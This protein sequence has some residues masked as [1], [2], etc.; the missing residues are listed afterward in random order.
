MTVPLL[1]TDRKLRA[2][3]RT[4]ERQQALR[5]GNTYTNSI[6]QILIESI[7]CLQVHRVLK[8]ICKGDQEYCS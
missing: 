2:S 5:Q 4:D 8:F 3:E 1:A 7:E 6:P